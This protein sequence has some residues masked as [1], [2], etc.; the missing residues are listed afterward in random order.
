[1]FGLVVINY[2]N[3]RL[4]QFGKEKKCY[5]LNEIFLIKLIST[6]N[7]TYL[8]HKI[9]SQFYHLKVRIKF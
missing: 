4:F 6:K 5:I 8:N 9:L 7:I 1:M 2:V 3:N